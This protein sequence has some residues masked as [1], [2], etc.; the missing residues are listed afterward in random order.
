MESKSEHV[1]K[2]SSEIIDD[3]ELSRLDAQS[4]LLKTTRLA[5]YI[6]NSEIR[7]WLKLEM[8]GYNSRSEISLK[9][10]SKTGRWTDKKEKK[11]YWIPLSQIEATIEIETEKLKQ[12]Q[13]PNLSGDMALL[14]SNSVSGSLN[15]TSGAIGKLGGV[16][17]RVIS[18]I[19]DFATNVFI[20]AP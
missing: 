13:I 1:L 3:I 9:Y 16:K 10:M 15:K 7:E 17:S 2:L 14:V 4:I 20:T 19:H 11:G 8:Q 18:L 6:D 12:F 5:R